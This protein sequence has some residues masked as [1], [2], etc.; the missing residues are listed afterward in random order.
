VHATRR[1]PAARV[2]A[3]S[4]GE[5]W[6]TPKGS[7]RFFDW[8][9]NSSWKGEDRASWGGVIG[10]ETPFLDGIPPE[11]KAPSSCSTSNGEGGKHTC[12]LVVPAL[13]AT[14]PTI[15][16]QSGRIPVPDQGLRVCENHG[17]GRV[18][19]RKG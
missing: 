14:N 6:W 15:Q 18:T 16:T 9:R 1:L 8:S 3:A 5:P 12:C 13:G 2:F 19:I 11:M 10:I 7:A 17:S 4:S